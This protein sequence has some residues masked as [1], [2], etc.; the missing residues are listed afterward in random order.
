MCNFARCIGTNVRTIH[1]VAAAALLLCGGYSVARADDASMR[2][3]YAIVRRID[4]LWAYTAF[5]YL[6]GAK[7]NQQQM[8]LLPSAKPPEIDPRV[9]SPNYGD[10]YFMR[11]HLPMR[12]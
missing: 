3:A 6:Y 4:T 10:A 2:E 12:R 8:P 11:R 1:I 9:F 7:F 5:A